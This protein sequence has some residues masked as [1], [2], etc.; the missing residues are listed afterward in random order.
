MDLVLAWG[1]EH[2]VLPRAEEGRGAVC[3]ALAW[4][5]AAVTARALP[6][7]RQQR[8]GRV[9]VAAASTDLRGA[10]GAGGRTEEARLPRLRG[11]D[12]NSAGLERDKCHCSE[13]QGLKV[14]AQGQQGAPGEKLGD[15][16]RDMTPAGSG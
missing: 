4:G 11:S 7:R 9:G 12:A 16:E 8:R 13:G 6:R 5:G 10:R 15:K 1:V 14:E 3:G 2:S